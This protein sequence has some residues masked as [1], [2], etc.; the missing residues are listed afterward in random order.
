M[1]MFNANLVF[2]SLHFI[3]ILILEA[4]AWLMLWYFGNGWPITICISFLL[5]IS[6]VSRYP[7]L[8]QG[9]QGEAQNFFYSL[10][11]GVSGS[12]TPPGKLLMCWTQVGYQTV[13]GLSSL[14]CKM[15]ITMFCGN[16][17]KR[18]KQVNV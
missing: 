16:I 1:N 17:L 5:T 9:L 4:L 10:L 13:L 12:L 7:K 8:K 14:V 2:F 6:Q 15:G 18:T 3:Q 11:I